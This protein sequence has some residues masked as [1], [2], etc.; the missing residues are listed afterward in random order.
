MPTRAAPSSNAI[1]TKAKI[2]MTSIK[3]AMPTGPSRVIWMRVLWCGPVDA[4]IRD[5]RGQSAPGG[6]ISGGVSS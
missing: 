2:P 1:P 4:Q 5:A 3:R 6:M